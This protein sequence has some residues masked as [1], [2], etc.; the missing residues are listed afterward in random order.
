MVNT[1]EYPEMEKRPKPAKIA[2]PT[3]LA[4]VEYDLWKKRVFESQ[5]QDSRRPSVGFGLSGGGIRSATFCLG[6]FQAL[7]KQRLLRKIDYISSVSGGSFFAAFY[8]RLFSRDDIGGFH[9]IETIL[10]PDENTR[11]NFPSPSKDDSWKI[12]IFRWL[13]ENGRYLAPNG[14]GDL[15]IGVAVFLRNWLTV[16]LLIAISLLTILLAAQ[17]LTLF[18]ET[19]W[20]GL[21]WAVSRTGRFWWSHYIYVAGLMTVFAVVPL[22]WSYWSFSLPDPGATEAADTKRSLWLRFRLP[23][24]FVTRGFAVLIGI[25]LILIALGIEADRFFDH[26]PSIRGAAVA[27]VE[28]TFFFWLLALFRASERKLMWWFI[29]ALVAIVIVSLLADSFTFSSSWT[30]FMAISGF[31]MLLQFVVAFIFA[32]LALPSTTKGLVD[33]S[34]KARSIL[35]Q[36]LRAALV[37]ALAMLSFALIDSLGQTLFALTFTN[38]FT[39]RNWLVP[40]FAAISTIVPFSLRIAT[41]LAPKNRSARPSLSISVIA[42]VGAAIVVL[43]AL[44]ALDGLSHAAAYNFTRPADA[45]ASLMAPQTVSDSARVVV[46]C[47]D[48]GQSA[49]NPTSASPTPAVTPSVTVLAMPSVTRTVTPLAYFL[50]LALLLAGLTGFSFDT[51]SVWV[52]LNRTSLHALYCARLIRAYLG[53]SNKSRY[54]GDA[55]V[56]DPVDGDDIPQEKYWP[57]QSEQFW[58]NGAPLHLVNVTINETVDGRSQTEQ[59]DRKGIGMAIGPAGFSVGIQHHVVF[60]EETK[61]KPDGSFEPVDIYPKPKDGFTIFNTKRGTK[62][63]RVRACRWAT[64]PPFQALRFQQALGPAPVLVPAC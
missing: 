60:T 56:T 5:P 61:N 55:G 6:V 41:A 1:L 58:R 38:K 20:P 7:T 24:E 15:L 53:A 12:G 11:L 48:N 25:S 42:G 18:V 9:D 54:S 44:V 14:G 10:S 8:G 26:L 64:G 46:V 59:R 35:S 32:I 28:L 43:P 30:E 19:R 13:R 37:A 21:S 63:S 47:Q 36:W 39:P 3:A 51:Q 27:I 4:A 45:P 23:F 29:L 34:E 22:G 49:V 52:F 57:R 16:Q 2:Y 62:V 50:V 33:Q 40:L 31:L 17:L